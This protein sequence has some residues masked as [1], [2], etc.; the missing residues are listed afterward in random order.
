[1]I[2]L[3]KPISEQIVI[4]K[5]QE[6]QSFSFSSPSSLMDM[7][8]EKADV[9]MG[10]EEISASSESTDDQQDSNLLHSEFSLKQNESSTTP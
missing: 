2:E 9:A 8:E 1:M 5:K 7:D 4:E 3:P 6:V 10:K